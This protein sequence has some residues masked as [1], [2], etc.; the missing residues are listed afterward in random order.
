MANELSTTVAPAM[1]PVAQA[2]AALHQRPQQSFSDGQ[3][4]LIKRTICKGA[5]DDELQLFI[6]QCQRTGLD[7]FTRQI[8]AVKRWDNSQGREVMAIQTA[9]DGFRLIAQRTG[10]YRGQIGPM[11]CGADG[12]WKDVWLDDAHPH[13]AKVAVIRSGFN[14]PLWGVASWR[15]YCQTTKTGDPTRFWKT[16][17]D[18]MLAKCAEAQALRKA[19][20]QELSGLH[21]EDEME[22][23]ENTVR[24]K[25]ATVTGETKTKKPEWT[26]EQTARAGELRRGILEAGG[27][28]A[29]KDFKSMYQRMKY[30]DPQD[31]LDAMGTM[32]AQ[33]Q[34]AQ[35][36]IIESA[37]ADAG[38]A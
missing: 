12:V 4:E 37:D 1:Q 13:A 29:D 11:W 30:D 7:P 19:F 5:T 38:K 18:V 23:S 25:V 24:A 26:T 15:S 36:T 9:I 28:P 6:S 3:K 32:L 33:W 2:P 27:E 34:D 22:Q 31:V 20:P 10:E 16:M 35:A 17:G 14:E 8:H 21:T